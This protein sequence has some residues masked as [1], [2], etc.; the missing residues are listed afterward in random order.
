MNDASEYNYSDIAIRN[1]LEGFD[2]SI[3]QRAAIEL[4]LKNPRKSGID[5]Y[6]SCFCVGRDLLSQWRAYGGL[7]GGYAIEFDFARLS[8]TLEKRGGFLGKVSYLQQDQEDLIR[9]TLNAYI[10]PDIWSW[11]WQESFKR[12][13]QSFSKSTS[14]QKELAEDFDCKQEAVKLFDLHEEFAQRFS[15]GISDAWGLLVLVRAFLKSP[16]FFEEQEW[17]CVSLMAASLHTEFRSAN[18]MLVPYTDFIFGERLPITR[19]IVGPSRHPELAR[20]SL[21]KFL[22]KLG[23]GHIE[24][25]ASPIPLRV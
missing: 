10:D 16:T 14:F 13:E 21:E 19:V 5:V 18:G 22:N 15:A 24:V 11:D 9:K 6:A 23:L 2:K 25:E 7:G 4:L 17:R 8:D 20:Q 12:F 3:V 1:V